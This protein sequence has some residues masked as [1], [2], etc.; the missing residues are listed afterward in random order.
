MDKCYYGFLKDTNELC[1][2]SSGGFG[3]SIAKYAIQKD[4]IVYGVS[5]T[6]DFKNA[7]FIRVTSKG[8]IQKL[9]GSKYIYADNSQIK[10]GDVYMKTYNLE[11]GYFS[12]VFHV[13]LQEFWLYCRKK[14]LRLE[15]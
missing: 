12:L 11:E 5:Y 10:T 7:E 4:G 13:I 14:V 9:L 8:D 6:S 15:I 2:S 3:A 1:N